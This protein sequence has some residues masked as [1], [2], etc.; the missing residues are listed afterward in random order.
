[1]SL[2][3][4][5]VLLGRNRMGDGRSRV[6]G[7]AGGGE[8]RDQQRGMGRPAA[9][10]TRTGALSDAAAPASAGSSS[11]R[12]NASTCSEARPI[13][14]S[15]RT[16]SLNVARGQAEGG[17][18]RDPLEQVGGPSR[19]RALLRRGPRVN[20]EF[21]VQLLAVPAPP[22]RL[23]Q[24]VLGG[25]EGSLVGQPPRADLRMDDQAARDVLE[26]DQDR[27][28]REERLGNGDALVRRVVQRALEPLGGGGHGRVEREDDDVAG[29]RADALGAHGVALVGHGRGADL[30]RLEGLLEL[31]LVLEQPQVGRRSCARSARARTARARR[32]R[33]A[34]ANRSVPT[35]SGGGAKPARR[36]SAR[37]SSST[38][39]ESPSKRRRND[40]CVPVAPLAPRNRSPSRTARSSSRSLSRSD[41]HSA[42]RLPTV[43]GCAGWKCV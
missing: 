30:R 13:S 5:E 32:G 14:F 11:S 15:G 31:A 34:C 33:P 2:H 24:H 18:A 25:Q 20:A 41:A 23:H 16:A 39:A 8:Q 28:G 22:D 19:Q 27:V 3:V 29:Q 1:M 7:R 38:L 4:G 43:V 9:A 42:A 17:V 10:H 37:S 21:L 36:A 26:Q 12:T 35:R 40:A 6:A